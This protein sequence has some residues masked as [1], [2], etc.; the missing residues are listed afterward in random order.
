LKEGKNPKFKGNVRKQEI[1][2]KGLMLLKTAAII[3]EE[4]GT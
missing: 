2:V 1:H 3:G 4:F